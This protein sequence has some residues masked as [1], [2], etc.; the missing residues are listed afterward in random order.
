[1][2]TATFKTQFAGLTRLAS[3]ASGS[4]M[5]KAISELERVYREDI[6]ERF[7]RYSSGGGDWPPKRNGQVPILVQTGTL[8]DYVVTDGVGAVRRN[9]T[10]NGVSLTIGFK[11]RRRH[12]TARMS[13]A[14]LASIH[15][16]G[17][18]R[19]PARRILAQPSSKAREQIKNILQKH[20]V[21]L[22][23]G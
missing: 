7:E 4:R 13:V 23:E 15:H 20:V 9:Q 21:N 22:L 18:G 2:L 8:R 17:L 6:S 10:G 3:L 16:L 5:N 11:G 14:D 19:V 12:P 1:M